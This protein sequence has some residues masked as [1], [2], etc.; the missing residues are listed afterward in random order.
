MCMPVILTLRKV[1]QGD[2]EFK[3]SLNFSK[4]ETKHQKNKANDFLFI[5]SKVTFI[6]VSFI[7]STAG[8][9]SMLTNQNAE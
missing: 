9:M 7:M 4:N 8:L 3:G 6:Q 1:S 2:T 5:V